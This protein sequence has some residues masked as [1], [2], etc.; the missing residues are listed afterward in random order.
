MGADRD[1]VR[2]LTVEGFIGGD[3]SVIDELI[4]DDFVDHD[5]APGFAPTKGLLRNN[6]GVITWLRLW[7][8]AECRNSIRRGT[9]GR[10]H[11]RRSVRRR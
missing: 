1:V 5:P 4:A 2:R 8:V 10:G 3:L 6:V 11:R 7:V 9:C